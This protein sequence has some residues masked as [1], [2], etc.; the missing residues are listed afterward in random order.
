MN[1]HLSVVTSGLPSE[2]KSVWSPR[3]CAALCDDAGNITDSFA[4]NIRAEGRHIESPATLRHGITTGVANRTG[5]DEIFALGAICGMRTTGRRANDRPGL[6]S[7]ARSLV[8]WNADFVCG[9]ISAL[10]ER[11]GEPGLAWR[12]PGLQI[13]D[14]QESARPWCRLP[15]GDDDTGQYR[16]P[17]RDEAAFELCGQP[18]RPLP[19]SPDSNLERER[20]VWSALAQRKAFETESA[21]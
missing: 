4:V 19:H 21:A 5:V 8:V 17:M 3:M 20:A 1:L 10:Y 9:V 16:R 7:C 18:A 13:V 15:P 6:V 2:T 12:R 14:L 11:H